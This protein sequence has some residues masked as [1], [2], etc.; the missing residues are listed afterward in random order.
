MYTNPTCLVQLF[1]APLTST[2]TTLNPLKFK[3]TSG[4]RTGSVT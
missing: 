4:S 1:I 3:S 2:F